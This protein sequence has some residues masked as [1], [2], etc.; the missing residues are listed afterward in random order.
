MRPPSRRFRNRVRSLVRERLAKGKLPEE[1]LAFLDRRREL[2]A[3]WSTSLRHDVEAEAAGRLA[4]VDPLDLL[5][6]VV[7]FEVYW[8]NRVEPRELVR[9]VPFGWFTVDREQRMRNCQLRIWLLD[10]PA[11]RRFPRR[12]SCRD[13]VGRVVRMTMAYRSPTTLSQVA[14]VL[15]QKLAPVVLDQIAEVSRGEAER[16]RAKAE[17]AMRE[18]F[19]FGIEPD[20]RI[21]IFRSERPAKE[22]PQ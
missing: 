9:D 19:P 21:Y 11:F 20:G 8:Q 4:R 17:N 14:L 10:L 12:P 13:A 6:T 15:A 18:R 5:A 3:E 16:E 2:L 22:E 7:A 1:L